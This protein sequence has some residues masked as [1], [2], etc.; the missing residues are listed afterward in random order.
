L[1]EDKVFTGQF[2]ISNKGTR[3]GFFLFSH[4]SLSKISF[5]QNSGFIQPGES[6][7]ILLEIKSQVS[8]E[9]YLIYGDEILRQT[10][11]LINDR[12]EFETLFQTID[13]IPTSFK[14]EPQ[15]YLQIQNYFDENIHKSN[16][17]LTFPE[18]IDDQI[19]VS[20]SHLD[21]NSKNIQFLYIT[22]KSQQKL[23]FN[24]SCI[25]KA[26]TIVPLNGLINKNSSIE[27]KLT[28]Q[29][30]INSSLTILCGNQTFQIPVTKNSNEKEY[31]NLKISPSKIL[32]SGR[33]S[34][35]YISNSNSY[36]LK[37][38][39][40]IPHSK[41]IFKYQ[42]NL[43]IPPR[44]QKKLFIVL[45]E[46]QDDF[47]DFVVVIND[48]VNEY[49]IPISFTDECLDLFQSFSSPQFYSS[50]VNRIVRGKVRISNLSEFQSIL[51]VTTKSPF[52]CPVPGFE[53]E[54]KSYILL[55]IHFLPL[56]KG[57]FHGELLIIDQNSNENV[58]NLYGLCG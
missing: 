16:I 27:I 34:I 14:I 17:I 35:C 49:R 20:P 24:I 12:S 52:F 22:N 39:T 51:K 54:P 19:T 57:Q 43:V 40:D 36:P 33:F 44:K 25:S 50:N 31:K 6:K 7:N 26:I 37:L 11:C 30:E 47:Q 55:P 32:F 10:R 9:L 56:K 29:K 28:A 42:T 18:K 1:Y 46:Y 38:S 5:S 8:S 21:F 3:T 23:N 15:H 53:T 58:I 48:T 13:S 4:K 45:N 2:S 41:S